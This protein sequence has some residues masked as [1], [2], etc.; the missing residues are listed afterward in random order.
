MA[1]APTTDEL[2]A[3]RMDDAAISLQ[4]LKTYP[5]GVIYDMP[6]AIVQP[7]RPEST[8]LLDLMPADVAAE[9]SA[10]ATAQVEDRMEG[11]SANGRRFTHRL[12]SRRLRDAMNSTG[13]MLEVHA[14]AQIL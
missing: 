13:T 12:A 8:G 10:L 11:L 5:S 1:V 6:T 14:Q 9:Y 7:G 3:I 2:I 4:E